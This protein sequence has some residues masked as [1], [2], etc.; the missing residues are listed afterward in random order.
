MIALLFFPRKIVCPRVW[1]TIFGFVYTSTSPIPLILWLI[2]GTLHK[3][4]QPS[5]SAVGYNRMFICIMWL[6][7]EN[8]RKSVN[9]S[10]NGKVYS[11]TIQAYLYG[12][13]TEVT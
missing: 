10:R 2:G 4:S 8:K 12:A 7:V 6:S 9:H 13:G 11:A 5:G 1:R 3:K